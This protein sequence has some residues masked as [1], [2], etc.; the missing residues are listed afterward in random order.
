MHRTSLLA[1]FECAPKL[2]LAPPIQLLMAAAGPSS[3]CALLLAHVFALPSGYVG[4]PCMVP[5]SYVTTAKLSPP[6]SIMSATNWGLVQGL[7]TVPFT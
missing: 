4:E 7:V 2:A 5:V 6:G 1:T 3:V